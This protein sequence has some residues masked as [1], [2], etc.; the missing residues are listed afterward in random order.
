[1]SLRT[2]NGLSGV[3]RFSDGSRTLTSTAT[4]L[5]GRLTI[6][7]SL[8]S[9]SV[10]ETC[11]GICGVIGV[12]TGLSVEQRRFQGSVGNKGKFVTP[13]TNK[14]GFKFGSQ[15]PSTVW[16]NRGTMPVGSVLEK[17]TTWFLPGKTR[18][19][20]INPQWVPEKKEP[21]KRQGKTA[22]DVFL[23][24]KRGTRLAEETAERILDSFALK[25]WYAPFWRFFRRFDMKTLSS[26]RRTANMMV[27]LA[28][29]AQFACWIGLFVNEQEAI[30]Q[31]D[32]DERRDYQHC[33]KGMYAQEL[34]QIGEAVLEKEDPLGILPLRQRM[35]LVVAKLRELGYHKLDWDLEKRRRELKGRKDGS[36]SDL[37]YLH[38][39]HLLYW[40]SLYAGT[41]I[42]GGRDIFD[43]PEW[44]PRQTKDK[45][46]QHKDQ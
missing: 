6:N 34:K 4:L 27:T 19:Q 41:I 11:G 45:R 36:W 20:P 7:V 8:S 18:F 14:E 5:R 23:E 32:D 29:L 25:S 10:R 3:A 33:I 30:R 39:Y 16:N 43:D 2:F 31:L 12:G 44:S 46:I 1:M 42:Y 21:P 26:Y 17:K 22:G 38:P 35:K 28:V 9:S 13:L 37:Q 40:S 24:N 15:L